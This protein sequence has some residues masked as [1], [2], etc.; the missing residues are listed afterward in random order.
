MP[1][2]DGG[3]MMVH[4]GGPRGGETMPLANLMEN[5]IQR[6]YHELTVL[7]ELL[8]R[9]TDMDRKIEIVQFASR[10]RQ[11]FIRLL[12]LVKWA[13]TSNKVDK[14]TEICNFLEQQSMLYIDTADTLAKMSRETLVNARLPNF[15]LPCAIDVLTLGTYPRLPTCIREKIVPP[16]AIT[17]TEKRQTL[18]TLTKVIQYRLVSSELPPQMRKLRIENGR[19][20][21]H[22]EHEFEVILTLMGDSPTIPWRLLDIN[23]LV[24]DPDTGDGK[25]LVHSLQVNYIHQLAQSRLVDNNRPL[26]D[27]Y[28]VL[29]SFCQSLQLEVLNSQTLRLIRERMGDNIRIDEYTVGRCL[30]VSYWRDQTKKDKQDPVV[31]KLKVHVSEEDEGKPLQISHSPVMSAEESHRVGLAIKSNHL[32]IERL[33]MQTIEVRIHAKLKDLSKEFQKYVIGQCEMKDLPIALH[34]PVLNP[35]LEFEHL[36]VMMDSQRGSI[37]A[38]LCGIEG[39]QEVQELEEF[40]NSGEWKNLGKFIVN[41]RLQLVLIRCEKSVQ[42]LPTT[43]QKHLPLIISPNHPLEEVSKSRFYIRVPKQ[44]SHYVIVALEESKNRKVDIKYYMIETTPCTAD[45]TDDE[46]AEDVGSKLYLRAGRLYP[47]DEFSFTHGPY[48]KIYPE[49]E[50]SDYEIQQKKRKLLLG[51]YEGPKN[52]KMKGSVYMIPE[53]TY[54]LSSCE[55][56]L[57]FVNL[58]LEFQKNGVVHSGVQVD[59]E[60]TCFCLSIASMPDVPNI[61]KETM[62]GLKKALLSLKV[63]IL[64]KPTRSWIVECL[65]ARSPLQ[66]LSRKESGPIQR[67]IYMHEIKSEDSSKKVVLMILEEWTSIANLYSLVK[68]FSLVYND[69]RTKLHQCVN[70]ESYSYRRLS[71]LYGPNRTN[72]VNIQWRSDA[73]QFQ[74]SLGSVGQSPTIN[75]HF[76]MLTQIQQ[77]LNCTRSLAQLS[78]VLHET[79]GP[80]ASINKLPTAIVHAGASNL[81]QLFQNFTI[82]P[83]STTHVRISFRQVICIDVHF[84][85]N[86]IVA[87]RDGAFSLFDNSKV[88]DGFNP[89][90]MFK[91]FLTMHV[92]DSVTGLHMRRIS[93]AEDDN[94]PSPIGMDAVDVFSMSQQPSIGSPA[95]RRGDGGLRFPSPM[96]PPSNPHTPASPA[97]MPGIAPSPST[98]LIGT[99]SPATLLTGGSPAPPQQIQINSPGSFVPMPSPVSSFVTPQGPSPASR[100]G[101]ATSPGHPAL[102]SP[103]TMGKDGDLSKPSVQLSH[104]SRMLPQKAWAASIPTLLSNEAFDILL[105]PCMVAGAVCAVSPLERFLGCAFLRKNLPRIIQAEEELVTVPVQGTQPHVIQFKTE[106]LQFRVS[107]NMNSFQSIHLNVQ[108]TPDLREHWPAEVLE[109]VQQFFELKI[110]CPPFKLNTVRAFCRLIGTPIRVLKDCIEIMRMELCPDNR[111]KWSVQWCLTVPPACAFVAPAGTP[112]VVFK[113]ATG[114]MLFMLQFTKN[115]QQGGIEPQTMYTQLLYDINK[116][117]IEQM[118]GPNLARQIHTSQYMAISQLLKRY[119]DMYQSSPECLVFPAVR[120][121]L[122]KFD[123]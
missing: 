51:E 10:T 82:M 7:S 70:I 32:S 50:E 60:G 92:D 111:H 115:V 45:G 69:T 23:I 39:V 110:A 67:V 14:C 87:L 53:L 49:S 98:N 41:L 30:V 19:V 35:T 57:A 25:S 119:S 22:V 34:V 40:L 113:K 83:Q 54:I 43:C 37:L 94:P 121:I 101:A 79:C 28:K 81:K 76:I 11:L 80:M 18:Q 3:Q 8:P 61:M 6:T 106:I 48:T 112:A 26:H 114:K 103:Q 38:S 4:H 46:L 5:I 21:F 104:S 77:E 73:K 102:H 99:P 29:H 75:P 84:R 55:E 65:F 2:A 118:Q 108:S 62:E 20:K 72:V 58:G 96:T 36:R 90:P 109:V 93:T 24:E 91:A 105:T 31:Y 13:S 97:R 1:P 17:P 85:S 42:Y 107:Y 100:H 68:D 27:L 78:Q 66:S 120:E 74:L 52:K 123:S 116:N 88:V 89:A 44:S 71:M 63:R 117:A 9:K 12:A 122:Q 64:C 86:G 56:R 33:L 95:S 15:S 47:L 16:D 59:C